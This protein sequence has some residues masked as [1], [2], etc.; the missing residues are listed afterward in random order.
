MKLSLEDGLD[1][2]TYVF[3]AAYLLLT[4]A[5][6]GHTFLQWLGFIERRPQS[7]LAILIAAVVFALTLVAFGLV[8]VSAYRAGQSEDN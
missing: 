5:I 7:L 3:G 4:S 1:G 6:G 2:P 8:S